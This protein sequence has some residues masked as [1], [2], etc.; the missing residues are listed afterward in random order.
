MPECPRCRLINPPGTEMCDCGYALGVAAALQPAEMRRRV[1]RYPAWK[2]L[3][4]V[5]WGLI[6]IVGLVVVFCGIYLNKEALGFA[7]M[8][9]VPWGGAVSVVGAILVGV[10]SWMRG[11]G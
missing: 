9:V 3:R 1:S 7:A 11:R 5:G 4:V 2:M 6:G 8:L 10:A